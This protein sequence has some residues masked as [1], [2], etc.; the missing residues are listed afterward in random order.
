MDFKHFGEFLKYARGF[1]NISQAELANDIC[2][3]RQLIR[4][5]NGE[6]NPSIYILHKL[7]NKLNMDLQEYYRIHFSTGSFLAYTYKNEFD[8]LLIS[9]DYDDLGQLIKKIEDMGEF[10]EGENLQYVLYG[11]AVCSSKLDRDYVLSNN[12]CFKGLSIED[13]EF[14]LASIKDKIYSNVGLTMINLMA[15]NYN[16]LKEKEKGFKIYEDLFTILENYITTMPFSMYQ[17]LDFHKKLYQ[18]TTHNLG[19]IFEKQGEYEKALDYINK[20]INLSLKENFMRFLPELL[21]QKSRLLLKIKNHKE[22]YE[23]YGICLSLFKLTRNIDEINNL[24]KEIKDAK[25]E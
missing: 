13:P 2:S 7:S 1:Y 8:N 24:E 20:G 23:T 4:I 18:S 5:E 14:D 11:K 19:V 25:F 3:T 6:Y 16:I 9:K 10:Q 21:R 17:S 12:F 15:N 22:S